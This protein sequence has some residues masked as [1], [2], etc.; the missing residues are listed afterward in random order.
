MIY[1]L[2]KKGRKKEGGDSECGF[3]PI[4]SRETKELYHSWDR[5]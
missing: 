1:V 2:M 3:G 5:G 4:E